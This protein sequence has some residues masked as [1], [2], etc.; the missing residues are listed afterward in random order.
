[1]GTILVFVSFFLF[2]ALLK[3]SIFGVFL[4]SHILY[5]AAFLLFSL[6]LHF[7]PH[8]LLVNGITTFIGR[9]SFSIYL[10]HF[11]VVD[12]MTSLFTKYHITLDGTLGFVSA[13]LL[14]LIISIIIS[15]IT[16]RLIETPGISLGKRIIKKLS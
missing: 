14:I 16:H 15:Y 1:M 4:P 2:A 12:T 13:Y 5:G 7:W 3:T 10:V 9:L 6:S 8:T 11:I